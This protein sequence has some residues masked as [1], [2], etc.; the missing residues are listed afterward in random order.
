MHH[1]LGVRAR[2]HGGADELQRIAR[3]RAAQL[4]V[5][6]EAKRDLLEVLGPEECDGLGLCSNRKKV[7][8]CFAQTIEQPF[9][10]LNR[11]ARLAELDRRNRRWAHPRAPGKLSLRRAGAFPQFLQPLA[12]TQIH[13]C[14]DTGSGNWRWLTVH[15]NALV[16]KKLDNG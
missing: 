1:A 7:A 10:S 4:M 12:D 5:V 11:G 3:Q 2:I 6:N 8:Q 14:P 16:N 15:Y 13:C 9:Q